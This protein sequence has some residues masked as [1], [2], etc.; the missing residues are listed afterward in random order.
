MNLHQV[1]VLESI[2]VTWVR[3]IKNVIKADSEAPLKIPGNHPG[4]LEEIDFWTARAAN[5]NSIYDQLSGEKVQKVV[6]VLQVAQSTYYPAFQRLFKDVVAARRQANDNTKFLKPLRGYF[7]KLNLMDEFTDLVQLFKPIMHS[8]MLIWKNA[9][10]YGTAGSFVVILRE[11]CN[12]LIMQACKYVPGEEIMGMEPQE[13]VD[14]LR[15]TLKILGTFKSYFFDYKS[16]VAEECP[17]NPWRFQNSALFSRL[18]AHMERCHDVLDLSQTAVQFLKLDRVEIGGTKGKA[19]TG[20][21][22]SI[23]TDFTT[24]YEKFQTVEYNI[25]E[26]SDKRFDDDFFKFRSVIR[27]LERRLG[28]IIVQA[29]DDAITINAT[30]KLLDSFEGL[31]ERDVIAADIEK[32]HVDLLHAYNDDLKE[33]NDIFNSNKERPQLSK[34]AA[35]MSGAVAWVGALVRRIEEPM[36]KLRVGNKMILETEEAKEINKL[37]NTMMAA[38]KDYKDAKFMAWCEVVEQTSDARLMLPLLKPDPAA[39][40]KMQFVQVNF[41][42][43]LVCLLKEVKY[44]MQLDVEVPEHALTIFKRADAFRSQVGNLD[45]IVSTWNNVLKTIL[46]VERPLLQ[47]KLD[48]VEASLMKGL[49]DLNWNSPTTDYIADVMEKVLE[50]DSILTVLKNNVADTRKILQGWVSSIMFI[51]RKENKVYTFAELNSAFKEVIEKRHSGISDQG[52][53]IVKL[54]SSSNR[55]LEVSKAA[56]SWKQYVDF[57]SDIVITGFADTI[58]TTIAHLHEQLD[59]ELIAKNETGPLVEIQMELVL[60]D[61]AWKPELGC[62]GG[63]GVRDMFNSWLRKFLD[64]G[65]LMKRLDIGEG[66]YAKELE[67]DF[68]VYDAMSQVQA[69]VLENEASCEAFRAS[70]MEYEYLFKKDLQEALQEFLDAEGVVN[71]EGVKD[72][73]TLEAFEA[74]IQKYRGVQDTINSMPSSATFGWIKVDAKPIKKALATWATKWTYLFTHYLSQRIVNSTGELYAFME[75]N[76]ASLDQRLSTEK[77]EGE[78]EEEEDDPYATAAPAEGEEDGETGPSPEEVKAQDQKILYDIMGNMRDIRK[79]TDKTDNMFEP[80]KQT[81]QMLLQ[82]DVSIPE[83]VLKQLEEAPLG[84]KGLKKKMFQRREALAPVQ[85]VTPHA[86][87]LRTSAAHVMLR[88]VMLRHVTLRYVMLC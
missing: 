50:V 16:R 62:S 65:G 63:D 44:F 17:T 78:E 27:E 55:T 70:F 35:P 52:K 59:P 10:Y 64:I 83:A 60:P 82:Y 2:V 5:L 87:P 21:V 8:L 66:D 7:D 41:D 18:D 74:Q 13:A 51:A 48:H 57:V 43:D 76:N 29:F 81:V 11:I 75:A 88:H 34:N 12:D 54:L 61:I 46:D 23:L 56:A 25:M 73:P 37:Y 40:G 84:W 53:E 30:F 32:K 86:L 45:I 3:Q 14:K 20:S 68:R 1:H 69:V 58:T 38:M 39:T 79:R 28:S 80:L 71:E 4:P 42:P 22:R 31:L 26:I 33:V 47:D 6:S 9:K 67:E 49:N 36:A 15:M 77:P 24:A 85:Q 72:E 19:L